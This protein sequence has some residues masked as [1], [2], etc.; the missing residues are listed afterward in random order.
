MMSLETIREM[1]RTAAAT[2]AQ[3]RKTPLMVEAEDI[4]NLAGHLRYMPFLGDYVPEG[5]T[6]VNDFFV[7]SSGFGESHESALTQEQFYALVKPGYGYGIIE[8]GQF[9]VYV[10]QFKKGEK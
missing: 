7:D 1:S 8:S 6:Q 3:V 2:A 9:Q 4:D 5:W 10:G